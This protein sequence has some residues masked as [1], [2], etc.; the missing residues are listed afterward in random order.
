MWIPTEREAVEMFA[1]HFEAR[2]RAGAHARARQKA[3]LLKQK[4]D[5]LG[6][7]I[8]NDVAN[9]AEQLRQDRIRDHAGSDH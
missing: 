1:R 4:G 2:H 7:K 8:W 5:E 9:R 6:H 3:L